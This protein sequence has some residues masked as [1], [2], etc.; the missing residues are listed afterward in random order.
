MKKLFKFYVS[1]KVIFILLI[2]KYVLVIVNFVD[3]LLWIYWM[4]LLGSGRKEFKF[5]E[6]YRLVKVKIVYNVGL[7]N[8]VWFYF[9]FGDYR[10]YFIYYWRLY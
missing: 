7:L 1:V 10:F 3:D 9:S 2:L 8:C 4:M 5:I 6:Y